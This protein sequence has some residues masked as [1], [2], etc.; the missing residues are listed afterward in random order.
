[1]PQGAT[2]EER[3]LG[4]ALCSMTGAV[5]LAGGQARASN[6]CSAMVGTLSNLLGERSRKRQYADM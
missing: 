5:H 1:M 6:H 4:G 2:V 3:A